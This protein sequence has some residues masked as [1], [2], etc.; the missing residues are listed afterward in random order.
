MK[1][2]AAS[3]LQMVKIQAAGNHL[4]SWFSLDLCD[5]APTTPGFAINLQPASGISRISQ[6]S[7][8]PIRGSLKWRRMLDRR[9]RRSNA[10]KRRLK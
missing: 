2:I 7:R 9:F 5:S 1:F 6:A 8:R 3:N 4:T 10:D